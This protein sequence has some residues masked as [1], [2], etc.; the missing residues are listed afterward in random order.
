MKEDI[1]K[2]LAMLRAF[3]ISRSGQGDLARFKR[4][5]KT[6]AADATGSRKKALDALVL[7]GTH[8][9]TGRLKKN[10]K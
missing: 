1:A 6:F 5:A 4:A 7:L 8:T 2:K 9:R 3:Q 10:Y